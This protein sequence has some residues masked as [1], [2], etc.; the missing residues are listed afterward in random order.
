MSSNLPHFSASS[1]AWIHLQLIVHNIEF[2]MTLFP[3]TRQ[4]S[5][6]LSG[7][8]S[9]IPLTISFIFPRLTFIPLLSNALFH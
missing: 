1:H 4:G 9:F 2:A 6:L 3:H 7:I 8:F 5:T